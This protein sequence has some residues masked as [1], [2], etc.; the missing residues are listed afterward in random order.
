MNATWRV[1]QRLFRVPWKQTHGHLD[2][3]DDALGLWE[4]AA[5]WRGLHGFIYAGRLAADNT[6][7]AIRILRASAGELA[8]LG[9]LMRKG[10]SRTGT[11]EEWIRLYATGGALASEYYS[12]AK[13]AP[14]SLKT[15][16]LMKADSFISVAERTFA[17]EANAEREAG[18]VSIRGHIFLEWGRSA[19]AIPLLERSL[20]LRDDAG[21]G[22]SAIG[23]AKVDL[24][25]AYSLE[26]RRREGERLL[27]DGLADLE[28]HGAPDFLARAKRKVARVH[29][30]GWAFRDAL[31]ELLDVKDLVET[32]GLN[33]QGGEVR[34]ISRIPRGLLNRMS[35]KRS[36]P[37]RGGPP[38]D[39]SC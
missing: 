10:E 32:Y 26:G 11:R 34:W 28:G 6:L 7:I 15:H 27:E 21:L 4:T 37:A 35:G 19:E 12:I 17:R 14:R 1:L 3:W 2:L 5:A 9:E 20:R 31:R 39:G 23:E 25:Y 24:G 18:L 33:D 22:R 16:Y 36:R 8:S 38:H 30:R 29:I 13:L